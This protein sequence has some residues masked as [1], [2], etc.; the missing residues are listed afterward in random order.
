MSLVLYTAHWLLPVS[1]PPLRD[2]AVAVRDGR[3]VAAGAREEVA[4]GLD[5]EAATRDLGEAALLPGF[6]NAHTHL[7][8]TVFRGLLDGLHFLPWIQRLTELKYSGALGPDDFLASARLG[9]LESIRSGV[10]TVADHT[11]A[12]SP[13]AALSEARLRGVVYQ[14]VFGPEE[15]IAPERIGELRGKVERHRAAAG[16]LVRVGVTPH[17][18]YTASEELIRGVAELARSEGMP[19]SIHLAETREETEFIE[20]GEG[21]IAERW[22]ERGIAVSPRGT[23]PVGY[24]ASTGFLEGPRPVQCVHLTQAT[25]EEMEELAT[26]GASAALCPVSNALLGSGSP[27]MDEALTAG[28]PVGLGTDSA[29]SAARLDLFPTMRAAL[30]DARARG[31]A[32][33]LSPEAVLRAAT[34]GGAESLGLDGETGS[35]EAGKAADLIAVDLG[36]PRCRP[37]HDPA[38]ALVLGCEPEDVRLVVVDGSPLY[39]DGSYRTLDPSAVAAAAEIAAGKLAREAAKE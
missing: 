11:D 5:G 24:L 39:E 18:P 33:A 14:E 34:L 36:S 15:G 10:T 26:H 28:L 37:V 25:A 7:E 17:S 16:P 8:Y 6:V 2:G 29:A 12:G 19:L 1:S 9:A 4:A 32:D 38:A 13:V 35:L 3:I 23:G 21:P 20:R 27:R 30:R 31:G 22:R